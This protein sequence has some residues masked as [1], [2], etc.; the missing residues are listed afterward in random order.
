MPQLDRS[1]LTVV[2]TRSGK[3]THSLRR[4]VQ[5][6]EFNLLHQQAQGRVSFQPRTLTV[7]CENLLYPMCTSPNPPAQIP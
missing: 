3:Q 2:A 6:V 5:I 4:T 7:I 1:L